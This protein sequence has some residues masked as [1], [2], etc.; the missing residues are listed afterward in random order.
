MPKA[1]LR[2]LFGLVLLYSSVN[3]VLNGL[4]TI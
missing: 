1:R 4:R 3:M 2:Q